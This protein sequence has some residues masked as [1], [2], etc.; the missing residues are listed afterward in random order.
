MPV[1]M[2]ITIV[3]AT[4]TTVCSECLSG[5]G[6]TDNGSSNSCSCSRSS[7]AVTPNL[8]ADNAA[9]NTTNQRVT[10][11]TTMP[12]GMS[13]GTALVA[14]RPTFADHVAFSICVALLGG[15]T[16]EHI[17]INGHCANDVRIHREAVALTLLGVC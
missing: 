1:V 13:V 9:D 5:N 4:V 6:R 7:A 15:L 17:T 3:V 11:N 12:A 14:I 2:G 16:N 10:M 8:I